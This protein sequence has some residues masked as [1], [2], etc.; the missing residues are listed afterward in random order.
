MKYTTK[1]GVEIIFSRGPYRTPREIRAI[2][3][4][5]IYTWNP[6]ANGYPGAV[7]HGGN[8]LHGTEYRISCSGGGAWERE[9]VA[10]GTDDYVTYEYLY[11]INDVPT[12]EMAEKML[13]K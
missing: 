11:P 9:T 4:G 13:Q 6:D 10:N 8:F 3:E 7:Q 12:L 5:K 2:C 1:F